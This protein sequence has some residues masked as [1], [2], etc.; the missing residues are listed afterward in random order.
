MAVIFFFAFVLNFVW[1]NLHSL[2]YENY[3]GR[4]ITEFIL[5]RATLADAVMIAAVA[6]PFLYFS[7]LRAH[8]WIAILLWIILAV[9]IELFALSTGRWAY[10]EYMPLVPFLGVGLTP[11]IQL[12][13]L[14][15]LS[16]RLTE[17]PTSQVPSEPPEHP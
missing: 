17:R 11:T 14:G 5:L 7:G 16:L 8:R 6:F 13:L 10:N 1:E 15:Y 9:V 4:P 12:A 3:M 2:L